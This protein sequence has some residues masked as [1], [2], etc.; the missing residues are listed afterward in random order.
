MNPTQ[1]APTPAPIHDITGLLWFFPYPI[2]M[3]IV[4]LI[5]AL[6]LIGFIVW[7][8]R[9]SRPAKPLT[10]KQRAMKALD[11]LRR[12]GGAMESYAFGCKVS[13]ALRASLRDEHGLDAVTRT[14]LE[15]LESLRNNPSFTEN[16]KAALA[17]FL[18]SGELLKYA[19]QAA[20]SGE[21]VALLEIA[22]RLVQG[23][24]PAQTA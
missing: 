1:P 16:E 5:V 4:G 2:W 12:E 3:L 10:P 7:L 11:E 8:V 15:F 21:V 18:E 6:G 20:G 17:E 24:K 19:R 9:R 22:H 14:S 23:E 13:D